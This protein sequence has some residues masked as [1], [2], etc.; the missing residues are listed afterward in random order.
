LLG[1]ETTTIS[2]EMLIIHTL[3]KGTAIK[4]IS[5]LVHE[6]DP[7][8]DPFYEKFKIFLD[9][10]T[11]NLISRPEFYEACFN[12]DQHQAKGVYTRA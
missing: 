4:V 7:L 6:T 2:R 11:E 3:D 10:N 5:K 1:A 9:Y 8:T 12:D